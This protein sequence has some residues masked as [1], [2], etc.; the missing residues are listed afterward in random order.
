MKIICV[1]NNYLQ[2]ARELGNPVPKE[3]V[4]FF[5]PETSLVINNRPFFYPDFSEEVHY[6]AELVIKICR[7]G[8]NIQEKYARSYYNEITVGID[9]TAR[10]LQRRCIKDGKPWE[11]CKSFNNSAPVG[12]FISLKHYKDIDFCLKLNGKVVQKANSND[13]IFS[14]DKIISH[15][16][17]YVTLKMGDLIFTGTPAGVGK[18]KI[19][20]VLEAYLNKKKLLECRIK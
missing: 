2:H 9:F 6:E 1:A 14:F 18:V 3:P 10:D 19:N 7:V 5:K 20:D 13:M 12:G 4:F 17:K 8:K 11:I 15:V 16:S